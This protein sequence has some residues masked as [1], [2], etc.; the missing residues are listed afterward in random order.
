M[1]VGYVHAM[2]SRKAYQTICFTVTN[3]GAVAGFCALKN[4]YRLASRAY[5]CRLCTCCQGYIL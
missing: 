5:A 3:G 4:K 2:Y 1:R